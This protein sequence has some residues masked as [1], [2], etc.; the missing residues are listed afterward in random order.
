MTEKL[1]QNWKI[2]PN[3]PWAENVKKVRFCSS[4]ILTEL[5]KITI[6]ELRKKLVAWLHSIEYAITTIN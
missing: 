1:R 2:L 3:S 4:T 6:A 5:P